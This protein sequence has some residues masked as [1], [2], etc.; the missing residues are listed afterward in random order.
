MTVWRPVRLCKLQQRDLCGRPL[1][2]MRLRVC[3]AGLPCSQLTVACADQSSCPPVPVDV[4]RQ[5]LHHVGACTC[6]VIQRFSTALLP[7]ARWIDRRT[8]R[9]R[10]AG[11][12]SRPA[13]QGPGSGK[14]DATDLALHSVISLCAGYLQP[15]Q[16][17]L[18]KQCVHVGAF[19]RVTF[20]IAVPVVTALHA[21]ST[22]CAYRRH[23]VSGLSRWH[24]ASIPH[25]SGH[26]QVGVALAQEIPC[27][28]IGIPSAPQ[29][30]PGA[31]NPT[32]PRLFFIRHTGF[33]HSLRMRRMMGRT[34]RSRSRKQTAR[35]LRR[36]K[37]A[38][39]LPALVMPR[40]VIA[41]RTREYNYNHT[42]VPSATLRPCPRSGSRLAQLRGENRAKSRAC[43][44]RTSRRGRQQASAWPAPPQ[45]VKLS[46][47]GIH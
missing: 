39:L 44:L 47:S 4:A 10:C 24:T 9:S 35:R 22:S 34:A 7:C 19:A 12:L 43:M 16:K 17:N 32:P 37:A 3:C 40:I 5:C 41:L 14:H 20:C 21:S 38:T 1:V 27:V 33:Q 25:V 11:V 28:Q 15:H 30:S 8:P 13:P 29:I 23:R 6:S 36:K 45:P 31:F 42:D 18:M 46:V 26:V 2:S